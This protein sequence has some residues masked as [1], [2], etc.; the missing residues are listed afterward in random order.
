METALGKQ[1]YYITTVACGVTVI[2]FP[3]LSLNCKHYQ[4]L[5]IFLLNYYLYIFWCLL[6]AACK[7]AYIHLY[8]SKYK[9]EMILD[10][11][12]LM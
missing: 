1:G 3:Q 8:Q 10:S 2:L 12:I 4:V 9:N 5:I 6:C 11:H 7:Y